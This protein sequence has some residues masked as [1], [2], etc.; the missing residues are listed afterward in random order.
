MPHL[1]IEPGAHDLTASAYVLLRKDSELRMWMHWHRKLNQ[2]MQFGGHVEHREQ[3]W[4]AIV[5][6]LA[7]ESGYAIRQ[8]QVLQPPTFLKPLTGAVLHPADVCINTHH[9]PELDH[10]HTDIAYAFM[11][12]QAPANPPHDGESTRMHAFTRQELVDIKSGEIPESVREIALFIFDHVEPTWV[13]L[14]TTGFFV[15]S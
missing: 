10:Y 7:E 12:D 5:H 11:T 1:H 14:D 15:S 2:W 6:E 13:P 4:A 3:P 9:F 8:L